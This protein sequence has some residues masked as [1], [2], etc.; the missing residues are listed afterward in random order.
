MKQF[1]TKILALAAS[2]LV[3]ACGGGGSADTTPRS[4]ITA[5]KVF[6]DSLADSG[7]FGYK[8]TVQS[9]DNQIYPERVA[10]S[11]GITLCN[12]YTFTTTFAPNS[13][14]GCTNYAIGGGVINMTTSA[15]DPRGIPVQLATA[16]PPRASS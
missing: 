1:Q 10:A 9:A 2:L 7:T 14:A 15:V 6:G 5:V 3:V 8:F 13:K 16:P 11:Y 12:F 4:K